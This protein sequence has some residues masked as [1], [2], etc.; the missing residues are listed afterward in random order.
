MKQGAL[1]GNAD[2]VYSSFLLYLSPGKPTNTSPVL[3]RM[4]SGSCKFTP[5]VL[6]LF[7]LELEASKPSIGNVNVFL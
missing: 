3:T 2:I 1:N 7:S 5:V 6:I 4:H